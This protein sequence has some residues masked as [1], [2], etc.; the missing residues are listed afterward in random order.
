MVN[1]ILTDGKYVI[2]VFESAN[3]TEYRYL[4]DIKKA[5]PGITEYRL[6]YTVY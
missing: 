1:N 4:K 5:I 6:K 3:G 2:C